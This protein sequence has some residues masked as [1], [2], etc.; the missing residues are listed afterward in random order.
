MSSKEKYQK[1]TKKKEGPSIQTARRSD[2]EREGWIGVDGVVACSIKVDNVHWS[3][4]VRTNSVVVVNV[5]T[6]LVS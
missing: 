6:E 2:D 5:H 4:W 1:K 3:C